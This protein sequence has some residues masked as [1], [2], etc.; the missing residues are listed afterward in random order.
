MPVTKGQGNPDWTRDETIL[1]L[2]LLYRHGRPI[3]KN[4]Q[5]VRDLSAFLTEVIIHPLETRNGSFRN[6]DGVAL[7][8][9]NL[10]SAVEPGRGLSFS[11]TDEDVVKDFPRDRAADLAIVAEALKRT[12]LSNAAPIPPA[13]PGDEE[14]VE[15]A[16]LTG[17]HRQRDARLRKKLLAKLRNQQLKCEVCGLSRPALERSL[18]ESL[19][20]AHHTIP[21]ATAEGM[22]STRV[23]DMALLCACCH[24]FI[25]KLISNNRRWVGVEEARTLI[26]AAEYKTPDTAS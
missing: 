23:K 16:W 13:P 2:D 6:S 10:L 9:Q 12:L 8:L 15:G 17:R 26:Q 14:F 24:R 25:H 1:A 3:D 21:L 7:K 5:D 19:F 22:R 18:Q 4:H 11:A 20:E